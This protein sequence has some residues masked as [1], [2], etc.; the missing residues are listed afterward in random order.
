MTLLSFPIEIQ[1]VFLANIDL[2]KCTNKGFLNVGFYLNRNL[3]RHTLW[4]IKRRFKFKLKRVQFKCKGDTVLFEI[5][6]S[7]LNIV[8]IYVVAH[9][10]ITNVKIKFKTNL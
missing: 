2:N 8:V 4:D 10:S 3:L 7:I 1:I 5:I 9:Y 6:S